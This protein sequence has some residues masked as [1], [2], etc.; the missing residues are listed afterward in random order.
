VLEERITNAAAN[1]DVFRRQDPPPG[2]PAMMIR[3]TYAC[4]GCHQ[5]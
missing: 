5:Q 1:V 4:M 3:S 2:A